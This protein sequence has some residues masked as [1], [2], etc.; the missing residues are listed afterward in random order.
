MPVHR[1]CNFV[2]RDHQIYVDALHTPNL[3]AYGLV[4]ISSSAIN[5]NPRRNG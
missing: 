1:F 2:V 5:Y 4:Q 3:M